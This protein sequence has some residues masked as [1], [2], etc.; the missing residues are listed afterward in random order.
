[1]ERMIESTIWQAALVP[2]DIAQAMTAQTQVQGKI[3]MLGALLHQTHPTLAPQFA[4]VGQ[5]IRECLLG[6]RNLVAH[7]WWMANP[8][9]TLSDFPLALVSKYGAKGKVIGQLTLFSADQ[10]HQLSAEIAEV[11][12]WMY[13]LSGLLPELSQRPDAPDHMTQAPPNPQVCATRRL[14]ALRP[15]EP[16]GRVP[17]APKQG[18]KQKTGKRDTSP[19]QNQPQ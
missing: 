3:D 6:R 8:R 19:H 11:S 10:L 7:G 2:F 5:Y 17:E 14:S 12:S 4:Q 16:E 18:R 15:P 1:M 9:W 13:E